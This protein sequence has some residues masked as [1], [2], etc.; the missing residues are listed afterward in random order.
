MAI[1]KCKMCGGDLNVAE[2]ASVCECE[3]CGTKQTVPTVD[4]EKKLT[5]FAR[6]NRLRLGCEFDK[7]AGVYE[8]IVADFPEEAE[9]YWGLVLCQYGIEYVDDPK[10]GKKI[11]TC[12]RSSF[13]SVMEDGNFELTLEYADMAAREVYR[14]EAKQIEELRRS[15]IAV[16]S[17][18]EPYDIFICY[19]ETDDK[20]ER[21]ID[22]VIA[23]DVYTALTDK[24]YRVFFARISLEDKLGVEYEPYIFAALHSAQVMLAFGTDYEYYNAVWV[25]NEWSRFLQLIEKGEK[26]T[27]IPCYKGIDAYDMPR[28]FA[29]LQAQDMGKV[30]ALQDL[31]RGIEKIIGA[32]KA[33]VKETIVMGGNTQVAPL[34]KRVYMFLED[35]EWVKAD[36]FCEQVLNLDPEC[37]QAYLG[38]LMAELRIHKKE[39]LKNCVQPFDGHNHFQKAIRFGDEALQTELQGYADFI[40]YRETDKVYQHAVEMMQQASTEA[41]YQ[42]AA[43]QFGKISGF[44]DAAA[45]AEQ[46]VKRAEEEHKEIVYRKAVQDMKNGD[47]TSLRMAADG[48]ARIPDWK[49]AAALAEKC[50]QQVDALMEAHKEKL[51]QESVADMNAGTVESLQKAIKG[52]GYNRDWRDAAALREECQRRLDALLKAEQEETLRLQAQQKRR[53]RWRNTILIFVFVILPLVGL[54]VV[55][56]LWGYIDGNYSTLIKMVQLSEFAVPE[57]VTTI[58]REA[59]VNCDS[60]KS[61]TIPDSVTTIED[62]AFYGCENLEKMT[63]GAGVETIGAEAFSGC[64]ALT[65]VTIPDSVTTI[66]GQAFYDCDVLTKVTIPNSVTTIGKEAFANC[67]ALTEVT[68]PD[69]VTTIEKNAFYDCDALTTVNIPNSITTIARKTFYGCDVLTEVTIPDSVTTIEEYAFSGCY[70]LTELTIPRSVVHIGDWAFEDCFNLTDIYYAGTKA[71]WQSLSVWFDHTVTVHCSDGDLKVDAGW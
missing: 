10:T 61:V 41:A 64:D 17:K 18:E 62:R 48:F 33:V 28:E 44:K 69:G 40:V 34:L 54:F 55:Y 20:G 66:G 25:K 26:K 39:D 63:I 13:E 15:I 65:E 67:D 8:A 29:K 47:K 22:S 35:G 19:K 53:K 32:D 2:G 6:A 57:G 23:Q 9:A 59:F 49:D 5:L 31:L 51:Y 30:G 16:S 68:I 12:H 4:D 24:G 14:A 36:D 45:L 58:R 52:F 37:A 27:L 7:A 46:C 38:K 11:P 71:K 43:E 3:Y 1:L 60:L 21:T 56:P 50:R 42:A 70:A